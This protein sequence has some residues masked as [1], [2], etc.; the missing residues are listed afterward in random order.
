MATRIVQ[1]LRPN[2]LTIFLLALPLSFLTFPMAASAQ[3]TA[4]SPDRLKAFSQLPDWTG[5]WRSRGAALLET[6]GPVQI[7]KAGNRDHPPYN[8]EWEAA[9]QTN[10]VRAEHQ[11]DLS[12]PNPLVDSHT[13]YCAAGMPRLVATPFDYEFIITPEKT[14]IVV[15]KET[16]HIYTDGRKFPPEDELWG[17]L[18]GRS[19]GHWEGQTLV[20][21]TISVKTG[22]W[23][24]T[25]PVMFSDQARFT[26]RIRQTASDTLENQITVTDPVAFTKPWSFVKH[27]VRLRD[28]RAWVSEPETCGGPE[29]RNPIVNGRVTVTLPGA[30]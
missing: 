30:K 3:A 7:F 27:Y 15:E 9:Y 14:W 6:E 22:L 10:L 5:I 21:E 2:A 24:D 12:Y 25:T 28:A 19:I 8:S 16:R 26:E 4:N 17:T 1:T 18:L 11:G 29:D 13:V 23:G 20:I